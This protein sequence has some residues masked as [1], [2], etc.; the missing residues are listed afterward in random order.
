MKTLFEKLLI[1]LISIVIISCRSA[2]NTAP[3]EK[4]SAVLNIVSGKNQPGDNGEKLKEPIVI[5]VTDSEN[6]PLENIQI[7]FSLIDGGGTLD[8]HSVPSDS[9]G[10][11]DTYW[12][13]GNGDEHILKVSVTDDEYS[14]EAVYIFAQTEIN[15]ET[16]WIKNV[17]FPSLFGRAV[18]HDNRIL[19]TDHYLIFSDASS[20]DVKIRFAKMAEETLY[21]VFQAFNIQS[22]REVGIIESNRFT[23]PTIFS[24]VNTSFP[25]GGFAFNAGYVYYAF[26]SQTYLQ[27]SGSLRE[28]YRPDL[29]HETVHL[30]SFLVGLDNLPNL[31]PDVWFSEGIAVYISNNRPPVA[32]IQE[33]NEWRQIPGNENPLTVKDFNNYPTQGRRWYNMFG[34]AVKYLLDEKGHGKTFTDVLEM[35]RYMASSRAGFAAAFEMYMGMS[36]QYYEDN[37][38][39][40]ITGFLN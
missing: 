15:I 13:L 22:G 3:E 11:A 8:D 26:D 19:E 33:L 37:F 6:N 31:W 1:L 34:T 35:Y 14:A 2:G 36:V 21:E 9:G 12:T 5:K 7:T 17:S 16:R 32:N 18:I 39:D 38:W 28:I 30:I 10:F 40:L 20:D 23:K 29:K 24:N 27:A 25:Y 4:I